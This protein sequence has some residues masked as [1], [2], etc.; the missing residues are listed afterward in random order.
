MQLKYNILII[1]SLNVFKGP[2]EILYLFISFH[3]EID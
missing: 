3:I 2:R 1:F